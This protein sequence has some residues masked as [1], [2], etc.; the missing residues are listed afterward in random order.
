MKQTVLISGGSIAGLTL[1]YWLNK[2]GYKVT[3][4][5]MAKGLRKGGSPVDVRGE[6]FSVAKDMGILEKI[7]AKEFLHADEIVNAT[8][9]TVALFAINNQAEYKGDIEIHREDLAMILFENIAKDEVE[10]LF[11]NRIENLV[12]HENNIEVIFKNEDCR[13]FDFVF[14]A[15]GTHSNVRK[16]VFGVE[17]N[18]SIFFG[19]Y[20]AF[21]E[22]PNIKL[23]KPNSSVLYKEIGNTALIYSFEK[24]TNAGFIF[25]SHKLHYD[26]KNHEQHK[27]ILRTRF[28]NNNAWKI[29]E[30]LDTLL[31]SDNLYFDEVCQ[32]RMDTWS[33]GRVALV[34]DAAY[35]ASFLTG[36]GTSLAMQGATVLAKE[37]YASNNNHETA[38][39]KYFET[40]K[41]FV[42]SIQARIHRGLSFWFPK[43]E[44]ELQT[45]IN[46]FKQ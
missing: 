26:Y 35:T 31:H 6:A 18:F 25:S 38:F 21:S 44:E 22:A 10:F 29:P 4:V 13:T 32:I 30:I 16:L 40:Y 20:F 1:A 12:Q 34:G 23:N 19:A 27:Q 41:P 45:A 28:E 43:T 2:F 42:D 17:E 39:S 8:N 11:D 3:V 24:G 33:K 14:G 9:E 46:R 37:L 36:M 5:E 7:K 15:D